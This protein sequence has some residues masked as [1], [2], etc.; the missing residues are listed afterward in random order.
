MR[1]KW[2]EMSLMNMWNIRLY[3]FMYQCIH[4]YIFSYLWL[5]NSNDYFSECI[6]GLY[7]TLVNRTCSVFLC[8]WEL[9]WHGWLPWYDRHYKHVF[10]KHIEYLPFQWFLHVWHGSELHSLY[11]YGPIKSTNILTNIHWSLKNFSLKLLVEGD[12]SCESVAAECHWSY[13]YCWFH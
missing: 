13:W 7:F 9:E 6:T 4:L 12:W 3:L 1:W 8:Y 5:K 10:Q 11:T 2:K